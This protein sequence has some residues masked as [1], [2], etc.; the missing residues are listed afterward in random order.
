MP[1]VLLWCIAIFKIKIKRIIMNILNKLIQLFK[2]VSQEQLN[3]QYLEQSTSLEDLEWRMRKIERD[4]RS[5][6]LSF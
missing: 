1:N 4:N 2:P 5:N 3:E 6:S